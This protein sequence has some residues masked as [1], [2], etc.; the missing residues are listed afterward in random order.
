MP[1]TK[2]N[3]VTTS[4]A[5]DIMTRVAA[6]EKELL[7]IRDTHF[8]SVARRRAAILLLLGGGGSTRGVAR[9]HRVART[10]VTRIRV[11]F[12]RNGTEAVFDARRTVCAKPRIER[13]DEV[14]ERIVVLAAGSPRDVGW[15]RTTWTVECFC[16]VIEAEMDVRVSRS[17]MGRLLAEAGVRRVRPKP[18]IT[19]KPADADERAAALRAELDAMPADEVIVY[20]DEMDLHLLPKVAPD[21]TPRGARKT[22]LTPGQNAR[23]YLAGALCPQTGDLVVVDAER[24]NSDL[25]IALVMTLAEVYRDA[26][27]IH[28]V[29]DNFVIHHSKKSLRAIEELGGRIRLHHLPPYSPEHNPIERVW[30][31][32]HA[33]VT[34]NHR[35]RCIDDL[36]A[37]TYKY[38]ENWNIDGRPDAGIQRLAA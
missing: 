13:R 1:V 26:P 14:L 8:C 15:E 5:M 2:H 6:A 36:L 31:D 3:L 25:F 12:L 38:I 34:R 30:W 23:R 18:V 22:L 7:T 24:K 35:H 27:C 33:C 20:A 10:L 32:V 4:A 21:W 19:L 29:V 37:A 16:R 28:V 17:H 11:S 9:Q